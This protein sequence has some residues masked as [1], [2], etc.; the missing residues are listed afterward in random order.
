VA[1]ADPLKGHTMIYDAA[2]QTVVGNLGW[3]DKGALWL[4]ELQT[5]T[6]SRLVVEGAGFLSLRAGQNGLFRLVHHQSADCAVSIRST[7][8][9]DVELASIRV[10]S[11]HPRFFGNLDLW[12]F[13]EPAVVL[14]TGDWQRLFLIDAPGEQLIDLDLSWFTEADYDL[15]YQALTDCLSL[16]DAD[17]IVVSVQRS[18]KLVVIDSQ[19]NERVGSIMLAGRGGNPQLRQHSDVEFVAS[20]YDTLC[21]VDTK[22]LEL[23]D[24][25]RLQEADASNK[26]QFIGDYD[27][28]SATCAVARPFSSDVLLL[29]L[30]HFNVLSRVPVAGQPLAV[31]MTSKSHFL[32]RDWHT[33]HPEV[34]E[35]PSTAVPNSLEGKGKARPSDIA[36]AGRSA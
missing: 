4:F 1:A 9:P 21:L 11:G 24:A 8:E 27:L 20:D 12:R 16:A 7:R 34:G 17:R 23:T 18:S 31:C 33:G 25:T 26:Q 19:R 5:R 28:G 22:K 29:D 6:E 10:E 35:F 14:V 3:V 36:D 15:G 30:P 13:V 32:A 2:A